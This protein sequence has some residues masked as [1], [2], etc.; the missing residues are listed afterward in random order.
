MGA[1]D[2]LLIILS[3]TG[4]AAT[5]TPY[6]WDNTSWVPL[7]DVT[8]GLDTVQANSGTIP[9]ASQTLTRPA[10]PRFWAVV[11]SG[12]GTVVYCDMSEALI[13]A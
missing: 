2:A 4:G 1:T 10:E 12:A 3:V 11:K 5:V 8:S 7:G 6:F 13:N 9:V